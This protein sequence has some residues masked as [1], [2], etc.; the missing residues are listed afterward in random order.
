MHITVSILTAHSFTE[1]QAEDQPNLRQTIFYRA[2][3][4]KN[5]YL[6]MSTLQTVHYNMYIT[7][8]LAFY[9]TGNLVI[10]ISLFYL[11]FMS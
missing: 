7:L 9:T 1:T 8:F 5:T 10:Y 4:E 3:T 11:Q 2:V 6:L